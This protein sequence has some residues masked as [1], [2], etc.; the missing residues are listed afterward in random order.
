MMNHSTEDTLIITRHTQGE[1]RHLLLI[2]E[3]Q[4]LYLS[5]RSVNLIVRRDQKCSFATG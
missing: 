5:T 3:P 2:S 1:T 4:V